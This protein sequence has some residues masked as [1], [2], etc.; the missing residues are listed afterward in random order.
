M[1]VLTV[2][3]P[4]AW[5]ILHG[6]KDVENR[7][8]AWSYRGPVA[9]HAGARWSER[10]ITSPL[11]QAA[12]R[13]H[14]VVPADTPMALG[15]VGAVNRG[16]VVFSAVLGVVD[17]IDVHEAVPETHAYGSTYSAACCDSPWAEYAYRDRTRIVHLVLAN[18]VEFTAPIEDV[19]GRLGLWVPDPDLTDAIAA[20]DAKPRHDAH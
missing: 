14:G 6:G 17:L 3:Q 2:Q 5:A 19:K 4:W 11:V 18:P 7:T 8:Q 16:A 10:G 9:I 12:F 15:G 13:E 1:R 20:R